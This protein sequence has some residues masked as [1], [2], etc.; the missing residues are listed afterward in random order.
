MKTLTAFILFMVPIW[1]GAQS[2]ISGVI[3]DEENGLPL[4]GAII[5]ITTNNNEL[6][7]YTSS[8]ED[9]SYKMKLYSSEKDFFL[10]VSF[11]GYKTKSIRIA[12]QDCMKDFALQT[13]AIMLREVYV[14][15]PAISKVG[16]TLTYRVDRF[17][18]EQDRSISDVLKK[19]PGIEIGETG[20]ISYRGKPISNFYIEGID[21]LGKRYSLASNSIPSEAISSVQIY[22]NHQPIKAL[23]G[24]AYSDRAALNLVL[25]DKKHIKPVGYIEGGVGGMKDKLLWSADFFSLFLAAQKQSLF[26]YKSNNTGTLLANLQEEQGINVEDPEKGIPIAP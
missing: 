7:A 21:L 15:P 23:N 6:V 12:N 20:S 26:S 2:V 17:K 8:M 22:E 16:D 18:R 11:L 9:G 5:K 1:V 25:K 4:A 3:S 13:E 24:L 19:M 10:S 14:T